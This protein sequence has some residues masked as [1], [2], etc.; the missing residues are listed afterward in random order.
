M[1]IY[2]NSNF[3]LVLLLVSALSTS[4]NA[5]HSFAIYDLENKTELKG[6]VVKFD[7]I[8]PHTKLVLEVALEDGKTERWEI[9]T[10]NPRR[11]DSFDLDR[12][13]VKVGDT[14][15]LLGWAAKNDSRTMALGTLITED[16]EE[17]EVRDRIRQ[18]DRNRSGGMGM[19]MNRR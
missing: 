9:E 6:K 2:S 14:I 8:Q 11:W 12:E 7:F 5:H 4:A 3:A 1:K 19:G 16:G 13:F 10:M 17:M 15:S 18:Q